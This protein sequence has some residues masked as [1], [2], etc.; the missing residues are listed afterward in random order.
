MIK[1]RIGRGKGTETLRPLSE[2]EIQ[3]KLYGRHHVSQPT[4][5]EEIESQFTDVP[6]Q[7]KDIF[8]KAPPKKIRVSIPW[9]SMLEATLKVL[10][11]LGNYLQIFLKAGWNFVKVLLPKIATGWTL[12]I[13]VVGLLFLAIHTLNAHRVKSMQLSKPITP[14]TVKSSK[15]REVKIE[16]AAPPIKKAPSPPVATQKPYVIQVCT[17]AREQDAQNLARQMADQKLSAF[18]QSLQ[19]TNGKTFYAVFLGRFGTFR[20]AQT[21]LEEFRKKPIAANFSDSFIRALYQ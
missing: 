9:R 17:Y 18:A 2:K 16:P 14:A 1:V 4:V 6:R 10:L 21:Q 7:A 11:V 8:V 13:V 12:S 19:R 15:E 3:Q 20:E 5:N